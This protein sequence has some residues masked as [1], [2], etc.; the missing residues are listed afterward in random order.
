MGDTPFL[1]NGKVALVTGAGQGIGRALAAGLAQAGAAVSV[2]DLPSNAL[3]MEMVRQEI[4]HAGGTARSYALDVRDVTAIQRVVDQTADEMGRLDIM[5]NNA[6]VRIRRPSLQVTEQEWDAILDVNLKGLFFCAQAAAQHML[7]QGNGRIINVASQLG[8]TALP[9]RAAYCASKSGVV[10]LTKALALEWY[11]GGVTVNAIGPGPTNT[12]M[13]D[14]PM[15]PEAE[16]ELLSRSPIGRRLEPEEMVG[17]V[18]F[19]A[20]PEAAGVNGQMLLVDAGWTAA[21]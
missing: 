2:T 10:N 3:A 18:V 15:T 20:S 9:E 6:G 19:L 4:E 11:S 8:V 5:V 17:A 12:P 7:A 1:L 14:E 21:Q 13:T 16:A